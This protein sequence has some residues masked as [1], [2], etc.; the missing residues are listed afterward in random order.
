[1]LKSI[2]FV[3]V[4]LTCFVYLPHAS[5]LLIADPE[6]VT[7]MLAEVTQS[8]NLKLNSLSVSSLAEELRLRI[9]IPQN[10]SRQKSGITKVIGPDSY[11][12]G[13]DEHGNAQI[14]LEWENPPLDWNISYL[15]EM[16]VEVESKS[17]RASRDF[18]VTPLV[19]PSAKII[20]T[21]YMVAGGQ[22][23]VEKML[24]VGA[25]VKE[26]VKYDMTWENVTL[27]AG[28][29]HEHGRGTCDE[30]S[31][32]Y[33]SMLKVL[34]YR[35]WY[36]AGFAYLGGEKGCSGSFG[37]HAWVEA[38]LDGET[39]SI[40]PTW[41]ESPVD[42]THIS[43]ARLPDSNFTELVEAKSRDVKIE[44][45]KLETRI[46]LLDYRED[47]RI[48]IKLEVVP[49][50][51]QSGKNVLVMADLLADGC[52]LSMINLGSCV[53]AEDGHPLIDIA[54][55]KKSVVFC[56][57]KTEY[58][59]AAAPG[60]KAGMMYRCPLSAGAGG[61]RT[62]AKL[63]ISQ[64]ISPGIELGVS[65]QKILVPGQ[66]LLVSV[67]A[68]NSGFG[69]QEL[70][71]FNILD[72][73]IQEKQISL[74]GKGSGSL[75]FELTAPQSAGNYTLTAFSSSGDLLTETITVITARH[76]KITEISIPAK[77]ELGE[78]KMINVT[79]RNFG[80]STQGLL[81]IQ[82]SGYADSRAIE[83]EENGSKSVGF[84]YAPSTAGE[85]VVSIALLDSLGMYQD[86]WVGHIEAV[87]ALSFK[88]SIAKQIED[89]FS[90][91]F[92]SIRSIFVF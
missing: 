74:A 58:W 83:M 38:E 45:E 35:S 41:A 25:W 51:V 36:V 52:V 46:N 42:A 82:I 24:S 6:N 77:M 23:S 59:T 15:V 53:S 91:L 39:Y 60:I 13:E 2:T 69:N 10:D 21:A 70:R 62:G 65:T 61:A 32:L 89:F 16:R 50:T 12:I 49:E 56:G 43:M 63:S 17:S 73:Q 30:Y 33:L 8:G 14:I 76:I 90:W 7:Y 28:W 75:K 87:R 64:G 27:A 66:S 71:I 92:E 80:E 11:R 20:E 79:L 22:N 67:T 4:L 26:H 55:P 81:K 18:R 84:S 1:M 40:D 37:A 88:E 5:A 9:Y 68:K 78:S 47:P 3:L 19:R 29:V 31:N 48:D 72:D 85:K 44:W 57:R 86:A 54:Q 34:G